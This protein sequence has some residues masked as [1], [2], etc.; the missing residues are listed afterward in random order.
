LANL[1]YQHYR[2][3]KKISLQKTAKHKNLTTSYTVYFVFGCQHNLFTEQIQ[4]VLFR[5][6]EYFTKSNYRS[7]IELNLPL[8]KKGAFW[9]HDEVIIF[10]T[11]IKHLARKLSSFLTEKLPGQAIMTNKN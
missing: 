10:E 11:G 7:Q 3:R 1:F 4:Q 6:A 8:L 5:R 2:N 9:N